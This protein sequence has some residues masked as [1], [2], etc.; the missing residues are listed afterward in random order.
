MIPALEHRA[1]HAQGYN[2]DW[3]GYLNTLPTPSRI[4]AF[5]DAM[6]NAYQLYL[7][8]RPGGRY[9]DKLFPDEF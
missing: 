8:P 5:R 4:R 9:P 3:K 2:E 6:I 7:Y 1:I